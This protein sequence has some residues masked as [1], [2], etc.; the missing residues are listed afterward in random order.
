M[1]DYLDPADVA[2]LRMLA[3]A[4]FLH[5]ASVVLPS[6]RTLDPNEVQALAS[7]YAPSAR[8]GR[9]EADNPEVGVG[10][11]VDLYLAGGGNPA[12]ARTM[13]LLREADRGAARRQR[14]V[15]GTPVAP[16]SVLLKTPRLPSWPYRYP[17]LSW[18]HAAISWCGDTPFRVAVTMT[19]CVAGGILVVV[20]CG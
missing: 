10:P 18:L 13:A 11:A 6:G 2:A 15:A 1:T 16:E 12:N 4:N 3:G 20:L 9:E 8:D 14:P 5:G 17:P 19:T 7:A